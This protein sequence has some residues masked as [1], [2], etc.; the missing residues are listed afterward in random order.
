VLTERQLL[1]TWPHLTLKVVKRAMLSGAWP[2]PVP[3]PAGGRGWRADEVQAALQAR[4]APAALAACVPPGHVSLVQLVGSERVSRCMAR[5]AGVPGKS[6]PER[7]GRPGLVSLTAIE[8]RAAI[9][10]GT[11]PPAVHG[12]VPECWSLGAVE[13][14]RKRQK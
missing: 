7:Q 12:V 10:A 2:R 13:T 3:L 11:F 4:D 6:A 5:R 9:A 8:L 14:W 1:A